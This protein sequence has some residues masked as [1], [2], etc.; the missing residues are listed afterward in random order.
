MKKHLKNSQM[1]MMCQSLQPL[2][3]RRDKIGYMAARNYRIL[4]DS[5][6]EY[7]TFKR[8]LVEKYG[9]PDKDEDGAD[10]GTISISIG[11]SNFKMFCE[12]MA[13]FNEMEHEIELM[14]GNYDDVIDRLSGEEILA[15]D[16]MLVD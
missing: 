15:I 7:E 2:L 3:S 11:S 12:E 16:W 5:L 4:S 1:V 10:L 14:V 9:E 6:T 8:S 13:P